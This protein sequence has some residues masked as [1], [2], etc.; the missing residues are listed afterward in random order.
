VLAKIKGAENNIYHR[1]I[2][3]EGMKRWLRTLRFHEY[4]RDLSLKLEEKE[5]L[6]GSANNLP[7][8]KE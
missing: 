4:L 3:N 1:V 5:L 7:D 2:L 8:F 6:S